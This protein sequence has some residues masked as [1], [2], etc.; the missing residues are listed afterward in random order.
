MFELTDTLTYAV[1]VMLSV[2]VA[3]TVADALEPKGIYDL[4]IELNQLPYLDSKHEYLWGSLQIS[5]VVC[6]LL[7]RKLWGLTRNATQ[8]S[9]D[10]EV[11]KL[12]QKNTVKSLGDQLMNLASS[13]AD[14]NGFP[15]LR[16]DIND[17]GMR[18]VGY[19]GTNELEH[20]LS[21]IHSKVSFSIP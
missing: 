5:D 17:D 20:A 11:I 14:D 7:T 15:I 8:I 3:K 18:M 21:M 1:P 16:T 6:L 19:I 9:R 12:H 13:E 2:L 10:V 4:V